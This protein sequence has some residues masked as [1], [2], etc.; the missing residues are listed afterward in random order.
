M[1]HSL[2][3]SRWVWGQN[4]FF[5]DQKKQHHTRAKQ[6][7][8]PKRWHQAKHFTIPTLWQNTLFP[9]NEHPWV[10]SNFHPQTTNCF[11]K[12]QLTHLRAKSVLYVCVGGGGSV[13]NT[14]YIENIVMD[15]IV[16]SG[17]WFILWTCHIVGFKEKRNTPLSTGDVVA[18]GSSKK[19]T[20]DK[21]IEIDLGVG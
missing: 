8:P 2:E 6:V 19:F 4:Y 7:R 15:C 13:S 16:W 18:A 1:D 12:A 10:L 20:T 9:T 5:I 11:I 21:W 14:P 17:I 3:K